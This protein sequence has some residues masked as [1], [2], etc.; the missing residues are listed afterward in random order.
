MPSE[1]E[2]LEYVFSLDL[3][4]LF[5]SCVAL[6]I[7]FVSIWELIKKIQ[8]F[9]GIETWAMREKRYTK[10]KIESVKQDI[11]SLKEDIDSLKA[12]QE[13]D[14]ANDD[15]FHEQIMDS[16]CSM[17]KSMTKR[18]IEE[19]RWT[20]LD[21]GNAIRFGRTYDV[22]AYNHI[23]DIHDEYESALKEND[24]ENGRVNSVMELINEKYANGLRDGFPI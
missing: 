5:V 17:K 22:E 18:N 4:T 21:F 10:E 9:F 15:K 6:T 11:D 24:M 2:A 14:R 23:K 16:I 1:A 12:Y 8:D 19:M 20:I 7:T 3:K 13:E